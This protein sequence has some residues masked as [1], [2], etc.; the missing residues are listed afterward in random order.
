MITVI[1]GPNREQSIGRKISRLV[2]EMY[3]Q[4]DESSELLDLHALPAE[5]FTPDAYSEKPAHFKEH[6]ID[7]VLASDGLVIIVPEY[8][9]SYPGVL[10]Y[11][12]DLLPFPE[13][14]NCRPVAFIGVAAGYYGGLRAVEQLQMV[15]GYRNA[16]LFNRRVFIPNSYSVLDESGDFKDPDLR[17]RLELQAEKFFAYTRAIRSLA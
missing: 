11:F 17:E 13:S 5:V 1:A 2:V 14:F 8:N 9:G 4:L 15:F 12:I 6:Y 10:K 3:Q 7:K 16:H